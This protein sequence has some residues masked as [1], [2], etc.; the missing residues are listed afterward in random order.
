VNIC[1]LQFSVVLPLRF[2]NWTVRV[3]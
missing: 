3:S 2:P 1:D